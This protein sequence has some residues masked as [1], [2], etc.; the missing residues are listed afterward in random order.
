MRDTLLRRLAALV[1]GVSLA[2]AGLTLATVPAQAAS[3]KVTVAVSDTSVTVGEAITVT[4]R[5]TPKPSSRYVYLQQR[6]VGAKSWR[7][8]RKIKTAKSG[9]YR[10]TVTPGDATDRYYRVYKPKQGGRKAGYSAVVQV[11]VDPKPVSSRTTRIAGIS[12]A[13]GPLAG[14]TTVTI[15]G[16]GLSGT[17]KVTFTPQVSAA[18]TSDGS[19]ILPELPG[20]V[21]VVDDSTLRVTTP[22]SLG[23]ANTVKVYAPTATLVTTFAYATASRLPSTFEQQVLGELNA[24]RATS[25]TCNG[26]AM[27]AVGPLGWAGGLSDLALSHSRDLAAR[28]DVYRGL[29]HVTYGTRD[30]T[31]RFHRA[32]VT[33]GFGEILALSPENYSASQVVDQWMTS[34][35]GHCESVMNKGWTKAGVGVAPGVWQTSYGPQRSTFSNVDFQ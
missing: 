22:A 32:G 27:P 8:V 29:S 21:T 35:T 3:F 6:N 23:G 11:V 31:V 25:Q 33:G 34:T 16:T 7:T 20:T 26:K 28:Q 1:T 15:S 30:F 10:T 2:V 17:T 14:G 24:R 12:P 18:Q 19:G 4:G 9:S 5:I 13:S